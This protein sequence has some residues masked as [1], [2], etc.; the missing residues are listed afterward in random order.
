MIGADSRRDMVATIRGTSAM[1]APGHG[2]R[3]RKRARPRYC[4]R[5]ADRKRI[6]DDVEEARIGSP[7]N[8]WHDRCLSAATGTHA[9]AHD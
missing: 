4:G 3:T 9:S 8:S 7:I 5:G 6:V 1:V 2:P